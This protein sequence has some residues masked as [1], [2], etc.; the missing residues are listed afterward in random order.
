F[1]CAGQ[2]HRHME[3]TDQ[4]RLVRPLRRGQI[5]I[6]VEFR[7]HLGITEDSVLQMTMSDGALHIKPVQVV[8]ANRGSQW[9]RELWELFAPM[10]D[11]ADAKGYTDDEINAWIDEALAEVRR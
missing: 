5:T 3:Q 4:V 10:R 7:R 6:P 1:R 8:D 2:E 9:F 11:E